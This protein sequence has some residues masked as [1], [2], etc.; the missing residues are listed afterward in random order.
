VVNKA[1]PRQTLDIDGGR[2][3]A[4]NAPLVSDATRLVGDYTNPILKPEAA[5]VVKRHAEMSLVGI[6]YPSPRN[7]CWPEGV[8]F[9]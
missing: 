4:A 9:I 2:L 8:P 6:G 5:E 3:P 7:Q 1:R